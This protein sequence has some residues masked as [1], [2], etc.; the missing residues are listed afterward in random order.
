VGR[1]APAGERNLKVDRLLR[2]SNVAPRGTATRTG[3]GCGTFPCASRARERNP[4]AGDVPSR[5]PFRGGFDRRDELDSSPRS[6][7]S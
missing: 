5:V 3:R 4:S 2:R 6:I 7:E 1:A